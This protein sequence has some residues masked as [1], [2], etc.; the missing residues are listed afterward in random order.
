MRYISTKPFILC[1]VFG[2]LNFLFLS[3]S[4]CW[5]IMVNQNIVSGVSYPSLFAFCCSSVLIYILVIGI[6]RLYFHPLASF[7]GPFW[8][9][10][11]V[12]PSW[13][14]TRTGDRHIWLHSLQEKYGMI[15][16][17]VF[18]DYSLIDNRLRVSLSP[19]QRRA[20]HA[21]CV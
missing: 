14:Y 13:W 5:C 21:N 16:Y 15:G 19:R 7:P 6:Y 17:F 2:S 1:L 9:R 18:M 11:S 8:A 20:K 12:V 4:S 10:L 3:K